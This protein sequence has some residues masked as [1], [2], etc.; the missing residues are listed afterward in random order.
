MALTPASA[1]TSPVRSLSALLL[2]AI[3][4]V[5]AQGV[6]LTLVPARLYQGGSSSL[7][8]S[9]VVSAY[10]TG[11]LLGA[12]L[13]DRLIRRSGYVRAYVGFIAVIIAV[14]MILPLWPSPFG[15]AVLRLS[16]GAAAAAV[17]LS[18]ETWLNTASPRAWRGRTLGA[19]AVLSLGAL[20]LSP[21][22]LDLYGTTSDRTFNL[23]IIVFAVSIIPVALSGIRAPE[24]Q[25]A[26]TSGMLRL[27]RVSALAP[28]T[29]FA[30]GVNTG[31][32]WTLAPRLGAAGDESGVGTSLTMAAVLLG[33][34][35]LEWPIGYLSDRFDRRSV[36]IAA[37][38]AGAAV[39]AALAAMSVLHSQPLLIF[40]ACLAI[41]GGVTFSLQPLALAHAADRLGPDDDMLPVSR[42]LLLTN[43]I[44][45][46]LGPL[47]GGQVQAA[48]GVDGLFG[49]AMAT[50][51]SILAV[52]AFVVRRV[53][54]V[55]LSEQGPYVA[56]RETTPASLRLNP[57][58]EDPQLQFD[59]TETAKS[60]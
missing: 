49:L 53:P 2:G 31:A 16:H 56:I 11:F 3:C 10:F 8:V 32:F 4:L 41:Y 58:L 19:Y 60:L 1:P 25:P 26:A 52:A 18:I 47:L 28:V 17:F 45:L 40:F 59:F 7:Q 35:V 9:L 23:A 38:A 42:G 30:A 50:L 13:C 12:W 39:A 6:L 24:A 46:A 34:F 33:G 54:A 27:I 37:A 22:L 55:P 5:L 57:R 51:G 21:F 29:A 43:G 14:V 36:L 15:W 20:G 48:V 44:G